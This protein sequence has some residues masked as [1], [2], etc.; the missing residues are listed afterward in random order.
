MAQQ[1]KNTS[2]PRAKRYRNKPQGDW[3]TVLLFYVLP[4]VVLNLILFFCITT[5][6]RITLEL[7]DTH[8]YLTTESTLR[9][10]SWFPTKSVSISM[11]GDELEWVKESG[12]N[13]TATVVKNGTLEATVTNINGMSS[14]V[15]EPVNI[16]DDNPPN[17][18]ES[19]IVE[20]ILTLTVSDSQSGINF[21]TIRAENT[22]GEAV[23]AINTDR[24]NSS[25]SYLMDAA[26]INVYIED[27]AGNRVRGTFSSRTEGDV[28][29]LEGGTEVTIE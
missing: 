8:D 29:I 14:T 24:N 28:E 11:D 25:V 10:S 26:G 5:R 15:F 19:D 2:R 3:A 20:G 17:I 1:R 13:Y 12:R 21:D 7:A 23:D 6:P 27:M 18:T 9:I 16:L 22:A 4:F